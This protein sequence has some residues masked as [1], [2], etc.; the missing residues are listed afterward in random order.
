M[1]NLNNSITEDFELKVISIRQAFLTSKGFIYKASHEDSSGNPQPGWYKNNRKARPIKKGGEYTG[2]FKTFWRNHVKAGKT[3]IFYDDTKVYNPETKRFVNKKKYITQNGNNKIDGTE[4]FKGKLVKPDDYII[5]YVQ[6]QLQN[7]LEKGGK[8]TITIETGKFGS[9]DKLTNLLPL[10]DKKVYFIL[11]DGTYYFLNTENLKKIADIEKKITTGVSIGGGIESNTSDASFIVDYFTF[12]KDIELVIDDFT[13]P[14]IGAEFFP[15]THNL[16]MIDL[17]RYHVYNELTIEV[18]DELHKNNCLLHALQTAGY[19]VTNLKQ[20]VKNQNVPLRSLKTVAEL[21]DVFITVKR[22]DGNRNLRKFG[23]KTKPLIQ[24][25]II[26]NHYFLVEDTKYTSYS[27]KNYFDIDKEK[28]T[29][30][31][32]IYKI[33]PNTTTYYKADDRCISSYDL[34][35][36]LIENKETHLEAYNISTPIFHTNYYDKINIYDNL[37]YNN[38]EYHHKKNPTGNIKS[39][40]LRVLP[41]E[42]SPEDIEELGQGKYL[43]LCKGVEFF[44]FET[45]TRRDDGVSTT[46]KPYVVHSDKCKEGFTGEDCG[47]QYLNYLVNKYGEDYENE[48]MRKAVYDKEIC[49]KL[50]AHNSGYDFRFIQEYLYNIETLEKGNGLFTATGIFYSSGKGYMDKSQP[51]WKWVSVDKK[52]IR[53]EIIDSL[54]MIN[55]G[56]GKFNECFKLGDV[57]KEIMPYDLY[58]EENVIKKYIPLEKC[59]IYVKAKDRKEY[60][61]NCKRWKCM[62]LMNGDDTN[63]KYVDIIKYSSEYCY[64]DCIT[65]RDGYKKFRTMCLDACKLDIYDFVSLASLSDFYLKREGCY[66]GVFQLSGVVRAFIQEC[67]VGGRTMTKNNQKYLSVSDDDGFRK[68]KKDN[69]TIT[70]KKNLV[71]QQLADFDGVS[72]YP[73]AMFR[74]AGFLMGLPKIIETFEPE[75]YDGYFIKIKITNVGKWYN[76]PLISFK[77]ENGIRQFTNDCVGREIFVDKTY[78]E[79]LVKFQE[80]E[81]EFIQGYYFNQGRNDKINSVIQHLFNQRLKYKKEKNPIQMIFKELMNSSYGKSYL[82]PIETDTEYIKKDDK[83]KYI[84][85]NFNYIKEFITLPNGNFKVKK[86]KT[87]NNHFNNAHVGV[88][89]L[90]MSKRIM[91]EVMC[92]ADDLDIDMYITDTDSIHMDNKKVTLLGNSFTTKYGRELIGKQLGQF[93]VD[94]DLDGAMTDNIYAIKSV[95]LGKKCYYDLLY[96][97]NPDGTEVYGEHIRMKGVPNDSI[98]HKAKQ[99]FNG[100]VFELFKYMYEGNKVTFNLVANR[101][102]FEFHKDMTITSKEEFNRKLGFPDKEMTGFDYTYSI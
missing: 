70:Q 93:H 36:I 28:H 9:I 30:F 61:E 55:M 53:V 62:K 37:D 48:N 86:I 18:A 57:K 90:S 97:K 73:S 96:S 84:D 51:K 42:K 56:L 83:E 8:N 79:D 59:L 77:D 27:I 45:S 4:I 82:K 74:M 63:T 95:F 101:P 50:I 29:D 88:E 66:D 71:S 94:F 32:R 44:D 13:N 35:K 67:I 58:T 39:N 102:K 85:R 80:V 78:L 12:D 10:G 98:L 19:D 2:V 23:D 52:M 89:I 25:A 72:L 81:Y 34:L 76:F 22:V 14:T 87:I 46:H 31:N 91:N 41:S 3:D 1:N 68:L 43:Y 21:L 64:M 49:V 15:Y 60:I 92:L 100:D 65:L 20:L 6:P 26:E 11:G 7:A 69:M 16:P 24:L 47:K 40:N 75:K 54:K 33:K 17:S 99:D 5:N 38:T